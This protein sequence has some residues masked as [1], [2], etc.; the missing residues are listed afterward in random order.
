VKIHA[1]ALCPR[2]VGSVKN[3]LLFL[4]NGVAEGS[5]SFGV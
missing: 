4:W 3:Q 5:K 2:S 1:V